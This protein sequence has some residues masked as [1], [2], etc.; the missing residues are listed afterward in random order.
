MTLIGNRCVKHDRLTKNA[1]LS[2]LG[3]K[4]VKVIPKDFPVTYAKS[5]GIVKQYKVVRD[6]KENVEIKNNEETLIV[7][8]IDVVTGTEIYLDKIP[9]DSWTI[10]SFD[11]KTRMVCVDVNT[12]HSIMHLSYTI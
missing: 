6:L 8:K 1:L 5:N 9:Y 10:A 11:S 2:F 3:S 12:G 4:Q 7:P